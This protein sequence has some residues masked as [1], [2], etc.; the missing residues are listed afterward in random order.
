MLDFCKNLLAS[1]IH[2]T[3]NLKFRTSV[4]EWE[5]HGERAYETIMSMHKLITRATF[6]AEVI[7]TIL[8]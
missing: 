4:E 6:G 8:K 3:S 1:K 7:P 5:A 2:V